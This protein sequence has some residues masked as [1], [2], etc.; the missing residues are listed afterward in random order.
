MCNS[1]GKVFAGSALADCSFLASDIKTCQSK[2]KVV[3]ISLGG[4]TGQVGFPDAG[5][6][7]D[8]AGTIWDMFLGRVIFSQFRRSCAD[9]ESK[10]VVGQ[11]TPILNI[12]LTDGSA[13]T[14]R[15]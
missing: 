2:G 4:A 14:R 5:T 12:Y 10:E 1:Y 7:N 6:A 3:T 13:E 8:F 15:K 9:K 11:K